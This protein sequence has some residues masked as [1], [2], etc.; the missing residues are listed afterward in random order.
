MNSSFLYE[1]KLLGLQCTKIENEYIVRF[2]PTDS[3]KVRSMILSDRFVW[4]FGTIIKFRAPTSNY[5]EML[6]FL[7]NSSDK[8]DY[9]ATHNDYSWLEYIKDYFNPTGLLSIKIIK[10]ENFSRIV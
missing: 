4:N 2:S 5:I 3:D 10:N 1:L 6:E 8:H 9:I 7:D